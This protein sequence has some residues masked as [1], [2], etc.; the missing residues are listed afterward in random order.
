MSD[1]RSARAIL[2]SRL[3]IASVAAVAGATLAGGIAWATVPAADGTI[4]ACYRSSGLLRIIDA[5]AGETCR[6]NETLLAWNEEGMQGPEGPIGPQGPAGPQGETGPQGEAG[7]RGEPGPAGPQGEP[8]PAGPQ[9]ETGPEGPVGPRGP[10][11]PQGETGPQGEAGPVGPQGETGP[12]GERGPVGPQGDTG[13]QGPAGPQGDTGATGPQGPAGADGAD[14]GPA[15]LFGTADFVDRL[16]TRGFIGLGGDPTVELEES[17]A[18]SVLTTDGEVHSFTFVHAP[19]PEVTYEVVRNG[20]GTGIGCV[21]TSQ[22][23]APGSLTVAASDTLSI[24]V[25][26][27]GVP[28]EDVRWSATLAAG[29]A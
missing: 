2:R 1:A 5:E 3:G 9:G 14:G 20:T 25:V 22:C 8:G 11:G 23:S 10:A 29:G 4:T 13:P 6:D 27:G 17:N 12:Q 15:Q 18:A 16:D 24:Q 28:L 7:P 19:G 21:T 26:H